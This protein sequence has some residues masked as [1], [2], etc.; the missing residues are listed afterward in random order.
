[1]PG[2]HVQWRMIHF[3]DPQAAAEFSDQLA[4]RLEVL[5]AGDGREEIACVGKTV[6]ADGT[7]IRQFEQRPEILAN[8]AA[9]GAARQIDPK[10]QA[11]RDD[12]DLLGL[13][14]QA[15]EFRVQHERALLRHEEHLAVGAVKESPLHRAIG[16]VQVDGAPGVSLRR[17]IARDGDETFYE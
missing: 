9:Y 12:G 11:A 7:E 4:A 14:A 8:I 5:V 10:A 16:G 1:M 17:S 6:G 15:P 13:Y 2:H 3:G